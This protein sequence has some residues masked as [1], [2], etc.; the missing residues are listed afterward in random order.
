[1]TR[2]T[3]LNRSGT[4]AV[5]ASLAFVAACSA[6]NGG[7]P[8]S[9]TAGSN[10][11]GN[12][13]G[14]S[15]NGNGGVTSGGMASVGIGT[16]AQSCG[17]SALAHPQLRRLTAAELQHSLDD[18]FPQAKGKWANGLSEVASPLGFNNDPALLTVSEQVAGKI[19]TGAR[20]LAGAATADG[21]LSQLLPCAAAAADH[22][23]AQTFLTQYGRRLFRRPLTQPEQDRYLAYFD[24][25]LAASDFKSALGWMLTGLV[26]SPH[27]LYRR[28]VGVNDAGSYK[29][30]PY[31]VATELSYTFAGTTPSDALLEQAANDQLQTPE[32][33][34]AA[35]ATLL[36]TPAGQ[37]V[38]HQFFKGWLGYDQVPPTLASNAAFAAASPDMAKET[39]QFLQE[40]VFTGRGGHKELLT[41]DF[42]TPSATLASFYGFPAPSADYAKVTRPAGRGVGVLAQGSVIASHSHEAASSPTLRGLLVF[43]RLLC[44]TKPEVPPNVPAL[45]PAMPNDM[46]TTRKRYEEQ[47]M[48]AG[49]GCPTC[50][51][52]F[53]PIGFGFE[54]YDQFGRYREDE[55]GMTIDS[56]GTLTDGGQALFSFT[57]LDDLATQL[58]TQEK[59]G[60]CVS[61]YVSAYTFA[62]NVPCLGE[63][64][65]ADFTAGTLGFLDYFASLAGEPSFTRRQ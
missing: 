22:A 27:A 40:V 24:A 23:C 35:A 19:L 49:N 30:T 41:A 59:V 60:R 57:G 14:G 15:S 16:L 33:L 26:Q 47:H 63:G 2:R 45:A 50:H 32:Q 21:V 38:M 54:H 18:I 42:T 5:F 53:D 46:I 1:V 17:T 51:K 7:K 58:A 62:S 44:G 4:A 6:S 52:M 31:E 55:N 34:T 36:A 12:G 8:S 56:S 39:R 48:S 43:Q 29:L 3:A 10:G 37:E 13:S 9:G 64:H 65:R 28:E 11:N 25:Q 20:A 61:G